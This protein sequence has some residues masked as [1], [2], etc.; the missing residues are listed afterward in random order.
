MAEEYQA[1]AVNP[2]PS[3]FQQQFSSFSPTRT[4][5]NTALVMDP[6]GTTRGYVPR[7]EAEKVLGTQNDVV[8]ATGQGTGWQGGNGKGYWTDNAG[9]IQQVTT[10]YKN[11][12]DILSMALPIALS[13]FGAPWL[14]AAFGGGTLASAAAGAVI[15]GGASFL[16]GG[17]PLKGALLGGAGGLIGDAMGG[18]DAMAGGDPIMGTGA[19]GAAATGVAP[20]AGDVAGTTADSGDFVNGAD[21]SGTPTNGGDF[22]KTAQAATPT[23]DTPGSYSDEIAANQAGGGTS[24]PPADYTTATGND[25]PMAP[26]AT[27]SDAAASTDGMWGPPGYDVGATSGADIATS[28]VPAPTGMSA[29]MKDILGFA[30]NNK[31]LVTAGVGAIGSMGSALLTSSATDKK[32][33]ADKDLLSQKTTELAKIDADK[34]ALV[35]SG[36]YFDANLGVSPAA[37]APLRRPDGSLV[38]ANGI[39]NR[40]QAKP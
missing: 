31:T 36:S 37:T 11:G 7:A 6:D 29:I 26:S 34:R 23:T 2:G 3:A 15:G 27:G 21:V 32:I 17:D 16:T 13:F 12:P 24:G 25:D 30:N 4:D 10:P 19:G 1:E 28:G 8:Q 14:T 39:I 33:Q 35:Q 38:Y 18:A 22:L 9:M 40:N 20:S 5:T